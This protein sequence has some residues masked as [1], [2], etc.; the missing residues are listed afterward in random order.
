MK[1]I[2]LLFIV[3]LAFAWQ[4]FSQTLNQ[5]AMWPNVNWTVTGT[6]NADPL[7][8]EADPTTTSNFAFDDDDAGGSSDDDIAAESPVIDL[9]AASGAGETWLNVT[10]LYVYNFL[11]DSLTLEYW[12]ADAG[13]WVTWEQ[14][15]ENDN[16]VTDNFCTGTSTT[17]TSIPL[18]IASFTATQLSGFRYRIS[19]LDDGGA[20]GAAWEWGFCFNSPTITSSTPPM[21][22]DPSGLTATTTSTTDVD[23]T[24]M[25]GGSET[26][27]TYEY[28]VSPYAQGGG[29]TGGTVM[30]TPSLS[31]MGLTPGETYDIYV[32]ANCGGGNGDSNYVTVQWTQPNLGEDC[33]AA[34]PAT[35]ETDCSTATPV[36]LDFDAGGSETLTGCDGAGNNGYWVEVTTPANGSMNINLGGTAT[37]VGV[38]IYDACGG[39]EV[40]CA[41]NN[42]GATTELAGF[43]GSTTYYFYFWQDTAAG[44]AEVCFEE[45][46]CI[47]TTNLAASVTSATEADISWDAGN[48]P[49]ETAWEYVVQAPGTGAPAGAGTATTS[50]PT[51]LTGLTD[52]NSYEFYV[53]ADCGGG[54]FSAWSGPFEWLQVLPP[55]NDDLCN[56]QPI[57][58]DTTG[59]S[60]DY[61]TVGATSEAS[62]PVAACFNAGI[63][64]SVW[65]SFMAPASGEVEVSTD[66]TGGTLTDTEIAVYDAAGVTC[67]DL[68][69][70]GAELGCDQDSGTDEDFNSVLAL[71]GLT[72][73]GTYYVQVDRWGTA[74]DGTFGIQVFDQVTLGT[75]DVENESAFTYYPNPVQNTLTLNAQNTIENITMYNMLGQEVLRANPNN[76]DS[77][78]D[79]SSLQNGTYFVKVTIAN[80][81]KTIRVIKQ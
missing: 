34:I 46:A 16:V 30:T 4:G 78:L 22:I 15:V 21:C 38:A 24:W 37:G 11:A 67:S 39:T 32:Q 27:W 25:A 80:V 17:F 41:N 5:N 31:L 40:F 72:P 59:T 63:N 51:S 10:A 56:A 7:A 44:V 9:T 64:G 52:G 73:G 65:F 68:S 75:S 48:T 66:Y 6:F 1:K 58:L 71:T 29:G 74:A 43:M 12:D 19:F 55:A 57:A 62:E 70:L 76:V 23:I 50:N 14:F 33:S 45:V 18:D 60:G 36:S 77:E 61:T 49:A 69:T 35:V 53:R 2:T 42:L 26:D 3:C 13:A 8:F 54:T 28:G 47:F 79:M 20:G 81:T